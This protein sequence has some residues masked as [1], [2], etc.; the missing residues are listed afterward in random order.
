MASARTM[1]TAPIS[2]VRLT[3]DISTLGFP[4]AIFR[5]ISEKIVVLRTLEGFDALHVEQRHV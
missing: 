4:E 1:R 5:Q 2:P 3:V